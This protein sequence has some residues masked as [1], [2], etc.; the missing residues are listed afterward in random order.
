MNCKGIVKLF[1]DGLEIRL[2]HFGISVREVPTHCDRNYG[3][4]FEKIIP[5]PV[6]PYV[7]EVIRR[8]FMIHEFDLMSRSG[9]PE[10][11]AHDLA[12]LVARDTILDIMELMAKPIK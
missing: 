5:N 7:S 6:A 12:A 4:R 1:A 9:S 8:E 11:V 3:V 10:Q 2:K